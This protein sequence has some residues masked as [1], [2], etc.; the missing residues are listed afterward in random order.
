MDKQTVEVVLGALLH[1]IGRVVCRARGCTGSFDEIG[2]EYLSSQ[3]GQPALAEYIGHQ[4]SG[5]LAA[6]P[7][8]HPA[9]IV[10]FAS[11]LTGSDESLEDTLPMAAQRSLFNLLYDCE[12]TTFLFA[13]ILGDMPAVPAEE[14]VNTQAAYGRLLE[15][16]EQDTRGADTAHFNLWLE[17]YERCFSMVPAHAAPDGDRDIS[18]YHSAK[19]TAAF[20]AATHANLAAAA[21]RDYRGTLYTGAEAYAGAPHY[22][23][24]SMDISGIQSFIYNIPSAGAMKNLRTR[25]FYLEMLLENT[26]DELLSLFS[27]SRANLLYTGGG[28]AYF[29]LPNLPDAETRIDQF[30]QHIN[31]GLRS[32]FD[33]ELFIGHGAVPCS[34]STLMGRAAPDAYAS[35]F[36][37]LSSQISRRKLQ[38]YTPEQLIALNQAHPDTAERECASCGRVRRN[39]RD[40]VCSVCTAF[41]AA[42]NALIAPDAVFTVSG[43]A[44]G[45]PLFSGQ[46]QAQWFSAMPAEQA[47][48]LPGARLY[49]KNKRMDALPQATRL[50]MGDTAARNR[51]GSLLTFEELAGEGRGIRRIAV[52]RADVDSLGAAFTHGFARQGGDTSRVSLVR[53]MAFSHMM[54]LF[55]KHHINAVLDHP[56]FELDGLSRQGAIN[57][58]YAGGDDVF[59]VGAW[60]RVLCAAVDLH[61][62]FHRFTGG[63]MT[64]SAGIGLYEKSYP[65]AMIAEET[66]ELEARA[67]AYTA[68]GREKD[69]VALFGLEADGQCAHLYHWDELIDEVI[70]DKVGAIFQ[71]LRHRQDLGQSYLYRLLSLAR[72]AQHDRINL[73]R[74]AYLLARREDK[75]APTEVQQAYSDFA[76]KA[77]GWMFDRRHRQQWITALMICIYT[78]RGGQK[79]ETDDE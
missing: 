31:Q 21:V 68:H 34:G 44:G 75:K 78:A 60:D 73:A 9:Y 35:V 48:A 28:H 70:R 54:S 74:L 37:G 25:S 49:T 61:S 63:V 36:A 43:Q 14:A 5:S 53:T 67:K 12:D 72:E 8:D 30:M 32:M 4:R 13:D 64:L 6:L 27:L 41:V 7:D 33:D 26:A 51:E 39:L 19:I 10:H 79:E 47:A 16:F 17:A 40:G 55:F 52:L 58:V 42:S 2:A 65:I 62:A 46:G 50:W 77:Y 57:V 66:G 29:L 11:R 71:L 76:Q 38:R 3:L 18:L 20:A 24:V 15:R 1:S 56:S 45:L 59:L 22:L 69:A 23:L